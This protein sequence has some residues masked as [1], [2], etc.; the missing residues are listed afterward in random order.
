MSIDQIGK[1]AAAIS[2]YANSAKITGLGGGGGMEARGI[3][4]SGEGSFADLMKAGVDELVRSQKASELASAQ[5][6]TGKADL[7]DVVRVVTEAEITLQTVVSVRDK[8]IGAYQEI[9][10]MPI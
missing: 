10:R 4:T 9:M 6:V 7:N 2:A 1:S 3:N 8:M 5:A